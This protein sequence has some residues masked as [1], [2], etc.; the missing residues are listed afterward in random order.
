MEGN[1]VK[2]D[3]RNETKRNTP[4]L[5]QRLATISRNVSF[6]FLNRETLKKKKSRSLLSFSRSKRSELEFPLFHRSKR[7][8][9]RSRE[10]LERSRVN[11]WIYQKTREYLGRCDIGSSDIIRINKN[12]SIRSIFKFSFP[13]AYN[14]K[15]RR[16][17]H[18][19]IRVFGRKYKYKNT[20]INTRRRVTSLF[21][22]IA[23]DS[24]LFCNRANKNIALHATGG[25]P[26]F[27]RRIC[28]ANF[29]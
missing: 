18:L 17:N 19:V 27:I 8:K 16:R 10:K 23:A 21:N 12:S 20:R 9:T 6:G 7:S 11:S 14:S 1:F 25:M 29:V 5:E 4:P 26:R 22:R 2:F 13:L 24:T 28:I 15:S 3:T